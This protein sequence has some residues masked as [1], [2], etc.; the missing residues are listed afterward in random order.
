MR[1]LT[2]FTG[3]QFSILLMRNLLIMKSILITESI[4]SKLDLSEMSYFHIIINKK[5]R[6]RKI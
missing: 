4:N 2:H 5:E 6:K 3:I 1:K